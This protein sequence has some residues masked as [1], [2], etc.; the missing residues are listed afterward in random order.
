M[1][2]EFFSHKKTTRSGSIPFL[3]RPK[4]LRLTVQSA[5]ALFHV[6]L[7]WQLARHV[8][9][10]MGRTETYTQAPGAVDGW[11]PIVSLMTLKRWALTGQWDPVHPASLTIFL[12]LLVMCALFRRGFCGWI[13][14]LG[15]ISNGLDRLGRA[16]G[17]SFPVS[18]PWRR[19]L[20]F[21][22]YLLLAGSLLGFFVL[23]SLPAIEAFR[24]GSHYVAAQAR[25]LFFFTHP[26]T[27][28]VLIL[29]GLIVASV[30][31]RNFWCRFLCPYG[32]LLGL[33]SL[34]S[35]VAVHR[36][37]DRCISCG[38]CAQTC[39]NGIRVDQQQ[40]VN[41]TQCLGCG[42]CVAACPAPDCLSLRAGSRRVPL[43][44]VGAGAVAV[45]LGFYAWARATGHWDADLPR[46]MVQRL[47]RMALTT[48]P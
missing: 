29:T 1:L 10:A 22:K 38:K 18:G 8:A 24:S 13:C 17:L 9:W 43:W 20:G 25:M 44:L 34:L 47:T 46:E 3:T 26:S 35:P 7:V 2:F 27:T 39:P 40:R 21:P 30:L 42:E 11:L 5:F 4:A 41:T 6:F 33:V 32:A 23:L 31:I 37:A 16:L 15:G 28:L 12:A 36:N 19:I 48:E 45:L 14:P